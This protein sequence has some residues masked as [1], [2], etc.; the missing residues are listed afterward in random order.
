MEYLLHLGILFAIYGILAVSLNLVVGYTG[1]LSVAHAA[2]Y[3]VGAYSAAIL[4]TMF[5]VSFFLATFAGILLAML[6]GFLAGVVLSRFKDDYY[7]LASLGFGGVVFSVFL[8]W[9]AVTKGSLGISGIPR[10]SLFGFDFSSNVSFF[11]L[12]L[13]FLLAV[14]GIAHFISTSSFGRVLKGIREDEQAVQVF[15]YRTVWYKLVV[16]VIAGGMAAVAGSLYASYITFIDPLSFT[17]LESVFILVILIFGGL[18]NNKGVLL[19]ALIL[20]L[21]PELLRFV[22]FPVAVAAQMRQVFYGLTL[23]GLMLWRPHGVWGD[24]VL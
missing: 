23:I 21:L 4:L 19:G 14:Y 8:N 5:G 11:L 17:L 2:F 24:Y 1:L 10:P 15:G 13:L 16:F 18:A 22:G 3:G 12:A 20:V 7:A 9:D 6:I